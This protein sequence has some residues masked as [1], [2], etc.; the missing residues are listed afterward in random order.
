MPMPMTKI[1]APTFA[2]TLLCKLIGAALLGTAQLAAHAQPVA[3]DHME[4]PFWWT[5]M[6]DHR[7]QLMVHGPGIAELQPALAYPGV[8]VAAVT[9]V[10]N[11]N[12]MF[13][14][15]VIGD[16]ARAG[17]FEIAFRT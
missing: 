4:P 2:S 6:Q 3:I 16:E 8:R 9:R 11:K 1:P 5:G 10:A 7:L 15:L 17:S 13:I 14:D 12:Y